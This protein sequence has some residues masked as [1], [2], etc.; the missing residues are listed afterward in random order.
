MSVNDP[1][2]R[3]A[4][5]ALD[6]L[7]GR[8][9]TRTAE[10]L[11]AFRQRMSDPT[12]FMVEQ[13]DANGSLVVGEGF[14]VYTIEQRRMLQARGIA[15]N[16]ALYRDDG[17][18]AI[19]LGLF[20]EPENENDE[21]RATRLSETQMLALSL[22]GQGEFSVAIELGY[23]P[24]PKVEPEPRMVDANGKLV[25]EAIPIEFNGGEALSDELQKPYA[26]FHDG[27]SLKPLDILWD[28]KYVY[29]IYPGDLTE[30]EARELLRSVWPDELIE[31]RRKGRTYVEFFAVWQRFSTPLPFYTE[32]YDGDGNLV[33]DKGSTVFTPERRRRGKARGIATQYALHNKDDRLSIALGLYPEPEGETDEERATR[34]L[35]TR[36]LAYELAG[37]GEFS[38][39]IELGY[40]PKPKVEP[41]P[42]MVD[43]NGKL[44]Q[45]AIAIE[46]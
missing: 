41:E 38:V 22:V 2:E 28:P 6:E 5:D 18:L 45:E 19:V 4:P 17:R 24:K 8:E 11:A 23:L 14:V 46:F 3:Q 16:F 25:Q 37:Q 12:P 33:V 20:P 34:L 27:R 30:D 29:N 36:M 44:V 39:A 26:F 10:Q 13:Y 31:L 1:E 15:W 35:E 7:D 21:E 9:D 42:R 43:A 40:L 32:A